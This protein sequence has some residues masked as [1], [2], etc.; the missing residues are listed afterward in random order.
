[1]ELVKNYKPISAEWLEN[2]T[3]FNT[4]LTIT[5]RGGE[6]PL[7]TLTRR[8]TE[9]YKQN[10]PDATIFTAYEPH[11]NGIGYHAHS[12]ARIPRSRVT[13]LTSIKQDGKPTYCRKLWRKLHRKFGRSS[14]SEIK[15]QSHVTNYCQKRVFDYATKD[16][17]AVFALQFGSSAQCRRD[18]LSAKSDPV[19]Y[20][21]L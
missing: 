18:Y 19:A 13:E 5:V 17:Q 6:T 9:F 20:P 14:V 2:L 10:L 3:Q 4:F 8:V 1:M 21:T 11:A 12:M 7:K 16:N 15:D